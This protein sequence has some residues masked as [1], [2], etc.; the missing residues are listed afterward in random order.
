MDTLKSIKKLIH[1]DGEL[2]L[3]TLIIEGDTDTGEFRL[4]FDVGGD[5]ITVTDARKS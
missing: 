5:E 2:V 4:L 3:E 1:P